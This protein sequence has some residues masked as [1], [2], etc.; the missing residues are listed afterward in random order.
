MLG[1]EV[2]GKSPCSNTAKFQIHPVRIQLN[3]KYKK[4][5]DLAYPLHVILALV[6]IKV[7][8]NADTDWV[9]SLHG[10]P[11]WKA[12]LA[13]ALLLGG[14]T[15]II[16]AIVCFRSKGVVALLIL[17]LIAAFTRHLWLAVLYTVM[18]SYYA[19]MWFLY[20]RRPSILK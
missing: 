8:I 7:I 13:I 9:K 17:L 12:K 20:I 6:L 19:S 2:Y 10:P 16:T 14:L 1:L 18:A 5:L 11:G 4:L 3:T 15:T